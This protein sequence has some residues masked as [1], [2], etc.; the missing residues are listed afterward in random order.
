MLIRVRTFLT[1]A[2]GRAAKIMDPITSP[3]TIM[4]E[5]E[6]AFDAET[7]L[8]VIDPPSVNI[9]PDVDALVER[10]PGV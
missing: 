6:I 8:P 10:A 3:M 7:Y 2:F 4:P 5:D 9:V 1:H